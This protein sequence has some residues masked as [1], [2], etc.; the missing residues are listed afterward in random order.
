MFVFK[1][2]VK[3]LPH[4]GF[5]HLNPTAPHTLPLNHPLAMC[6]RT[7]PSL[8][9]QVLMKRGDGGGSQLQEQAPA[10]LGYCPQEDPL[11]LDLTPQQHLRVYAAVKG[12]RKEDTAAAVGRYG[13]RVGMVNVPSSGHGEGTRESKFT[14]ETM[15][16]TQETQLQKCCCAQCCA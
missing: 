5:P 3:S 7:M 13:W 10:F 11:W 2:S 1:N 12:L 15:K 4:R 16:E 8:V 9:V 6:E 14:H